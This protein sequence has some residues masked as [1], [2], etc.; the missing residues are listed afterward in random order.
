MSS[1]ALLTQTAG[2][3]TATG[4]TAGV[5]MPKARILGNLYMRAIWSAAANASGANSVVLS[6]DLSLDAGGTWNEL[7]GSQPIV[8]SVTPQ[9]GETYLELDL[10]DPRINAAMANAPI[11]RLTYTFSGAGA[12]PTINISSVEI[13]PAWS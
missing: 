10:I 1:D 2:V 5:T 3:K 6:T 8:L 7:A 13:V 4:S 11:V 9:S 12:S